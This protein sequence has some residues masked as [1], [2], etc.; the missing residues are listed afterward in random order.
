MVIESKLFP[1]PRATSLLCW[2]DNCFPLEVEFSP[3]P[4]SKGFSELWEKLF[5]Y[6]HDSLYE[7][8]FHTRLRRCWAG[9][10]RA[11]SSKQR[12]LMCNVW[13]NFSLPHSFGGKKKFFS[14]ACDERESFPTP[15]SARVCNKNHLFIW[16]MNSEIMRSS[17]II[18][19]FHL[20]DSSL[21]ERETRWWETGS[22]HQLSALFLF[23]FTP[24]ASKVT[25]KRKMMSARVEGEEKTENSQKNSTEMSF[26]TRHL[27]S[28]WATIQLIQ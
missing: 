7:N 19:F 12:F 8:Q 18:F 25:F 17:I 28:G 22:S 21:V 5:T 20:T 23:L 26:I 3:L 9:G 27:L 4:T 14:V 1:L 10:G 13:E 15:W 11:A 24:S 2:D 6:L 16:W